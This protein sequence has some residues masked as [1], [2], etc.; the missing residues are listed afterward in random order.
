MAPILIA[1]FVLIFVI[2]SVIDLKKQRLLS[3]RQKTNL[4][5][6]MVAVPFAGS[7]IYFLL[8]DSLVKS[9]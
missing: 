5:F 4:L 1:L 6:L 7:I 8:K 9:R 2:F 3:E